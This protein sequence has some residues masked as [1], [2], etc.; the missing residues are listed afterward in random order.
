MGELIFSFVYGGSLIV[1]GLVTR[2][3]LKKMEKTKKM[4]FSDESIEL[5][6]ELDNVK[7]YEKVV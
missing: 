3:F 6:E 5:I 1:M 7:H 2:M 4:D